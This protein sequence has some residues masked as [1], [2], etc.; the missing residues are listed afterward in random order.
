M[1]KS[2]SMEPYHKLWILL[3][4]VSHLMYNARE[5]DLKQQ[6]ITS[7]QSAMLFHIM[8]LGGK[9]TPA[10]IS[11]VSMRAHH[12]ISINLA[13][14]KKRGLVNTEK[15]VDNKGMISVTMTKKGK[16]AYK[17][18][19]ELES[20]KNIMSCLSEE[21]SQ[22]LSSILVKLNKKTMEELHVNTGLPFD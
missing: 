8:E 20:I 21:D 14:M 16:Q 13:L 18:A 1:K 11:R 3:H 22:Q 19:M 9:A 7:R 12:T 10:E 17:Q 6:G 2:V 4:R 5:K 15:N